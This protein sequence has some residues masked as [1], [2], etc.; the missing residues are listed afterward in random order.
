MFPAS[1]A[2]IKDKSQIMRRAKRVLMCWE[3]GSGNGHVRQ[4][5]LIGERLQKQGFAV[6]YALRRPE[7]GAA[8]GIPAEATRAAPNWPL[9]S[10]PPE[11]RKAMTSA[12]YGDYLAQLMLGPQDNLSARLQR[13]NKLIETERPDL[14]IADYA[15]SVSLLFHGRIPII[16]I[17]NGY[18][19]PPTSLKS[20]P[21][22]IDDVRMQ[23]AE[24]DVVE[25]INQAL[26]PYNKT[27]ISHFPQI[28]RADRSYLL[29]FPV[30]DPYREH[31]EGGWL[32][33]PDTKEIVLA[34]RPAKRLFAYFQEQQQTDARLI[35]GL[36]KAGLNGKAI[37]SLPLRK[38][39]K[40]LEPAGI[41]VPDGLAYL[42]IEL[43]SCRVIVH[44]GSA[45][46]AMAGIAAGVP[47][48]MI[49]TDLEKTL[50]AQA[51]AGRNAGTVLSW[52]TFEMLDLA[53]AIRT[54]AES[55]KMQ[56]AARDL[57]LENTRYLQLDP[58]AEIVKGV[59]ETIGD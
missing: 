25:I 24:N 8:V 18:V 21:R 9:R 5:K 29:T 55:E 32:G 2:I 52:S 15:P 36:I 45:G 50:V 46:M 35:E 28:N 54:A 14:I 17:G 23:Y 39:I 38:T 31:R 53:V 40:M 20:F 4:L 3:F 42:P 11:D 19:L 43:L 51:I 34:M 44:A 37:F 7:A 58:V 56:K 1:I 47:Q 13:W 27:P 26:H 57:S 12:T 16:A 48:V 49:K 59:T 10:L 33:T 6:T 41:S 22:L 30:L